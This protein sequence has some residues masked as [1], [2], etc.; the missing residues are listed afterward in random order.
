MAVTP[1][2]LIQPLG[3]IAASFFPDDSPPPAAGEGS[4]LGRLQAYIDRALEKVSTLVLTNSDPA[5]RAWALH[6]AFDDAHTGMAARYAS[7][8]LLGGLGGYTFNAEQLK[9]FEKKAKE[10]AAV[11]DAE[12]LNAGSLTQP[13]TPQSRE[14]PVLFD[15]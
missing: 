1:A 11:Y 8:Q 6:L 3:P 4:L 9:V 12:V 14:T 13:H 10:Y 15:W 5:V 7:E 2:S